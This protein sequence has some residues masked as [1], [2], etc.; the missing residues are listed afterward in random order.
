MVAFPFAHDPEGRNCVVVLCITSSGLLLVEG[1][2]MVGGGLHGYNA[3]GIACPSYH[4]SKLK[5]EL[6]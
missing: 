4:P 6:G 2:V 3:G 5:A 1:A